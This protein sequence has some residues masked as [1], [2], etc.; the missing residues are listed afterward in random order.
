MTARVYDLEMGIIIVYLLVYNTCYN[1]WA[2]KLEFG[3]YKYCIRI[4]SFGDKL[5]ARFD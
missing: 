3:L 5:Y 2:G 4:Y 1:L